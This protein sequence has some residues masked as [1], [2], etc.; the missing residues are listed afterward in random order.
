MEVPLLLQF[1]IALFTGMVAATFIP[2]VRR[3]IPKPAEVALWIALVGVCFAGVTSVTDPNVREMSSSAVWGVDQM[4]N[5]LVGA[6]FGGILGAIFDHRFWIASWLVIIA[7]ADLLALVLLRSRRQGQAWQPRV[8]LREWM[9]MP[10][11]RAAVQEPVRVA[12]PIADLNRRLAAGIAIAGTTMLTN[13]LDFSIWVRDVLV[14]GQR[15]MLTAAARAG[16]VRSRAS[17]E[18]LRDSAAHLQHA[19]LS[20]YAAAGQ[21][22]VDVAVNGIAGKATGAVRQAQHARRALGPVTARAGQVVDIRGVL[23][24]QSIGWYGPFMA[25]PTTVLG[26]GESDEPESQKRSDRLAS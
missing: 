18:S 13:V 3:S 16:R 1:S 2:P 12:D 15:T 6:I 10:P 7:G 4:I 25:A 17:L 21:P 8:R 9:E 14:P 11:A 22:A 26:E 5:S 24:A 19:A 23:N 20:W